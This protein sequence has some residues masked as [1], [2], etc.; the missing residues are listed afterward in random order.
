M[1]HY[2]AF[3]TNGVGVPQ[4]LIASSFV[5][6]GAVGG[7]IALVQCLFLFSFVLLPRWCDCSCDV[8]V[9]S[10]HSAHTNLPTMNMPLRTISS[11]LSSYSL[12]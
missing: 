2:I 7:A 12:C 5:Y 1:V 3:T 8:H 6:A 11:L 10:L 4:V 9:C